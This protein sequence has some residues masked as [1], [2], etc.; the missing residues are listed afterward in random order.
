MRQGDLE[1]H[2]GAGSPAAMAFQ[3]FSLLPTPLLGGGALHPISVG[4]LVSAAGNR[5]AGDCGTPNAIDVVV[6]EAAYGRTRLPGGPAPGLRK[7]AGPP[8]S[9]G[10]TQ[11]AGNGTRVRFPAAPPGLRRAMI[12]AFPGFAHAIRR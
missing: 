3:R 12:A 2:P 5:P 9:G 10:A 11:R 1:G 6:R 4:G 8:G 7:E